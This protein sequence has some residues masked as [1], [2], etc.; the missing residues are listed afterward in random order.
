MIISIA[1]ELIEELE[2]DIVIVS[3]NCE[4]HLATGESC[5]EPGALT[6][7]TLS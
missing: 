5:N 2:V 7:H 6:S 4:F 1:D 3:V